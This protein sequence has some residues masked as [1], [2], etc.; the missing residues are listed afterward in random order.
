MKLLSRNWYARDTLS[1]ARDLL[2]KVLVVGG[3]RVRLVETEAYHGDDPASHCRN[4]PTDRCRVMFGP[5]GVAYVYFI[6]GMYEMLNLVTERPGYPGAVLIRG[7]LPLSG[8]PA[9]VRL[10]GPGKLCRALGIKLSDTGRFFRVYDDGFRP[11]RVLR[12]PR[13]G[14]SAGTEKL[15]RFVAAEPGLV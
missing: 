7:A 10:D 14:I 12:T 5:A 8:L 13:V 11:R 4:G 2:G 9:G 3:A 15:W 1:V 6:Y